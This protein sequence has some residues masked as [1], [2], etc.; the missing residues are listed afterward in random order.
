MSGL[1]SMELHLSYPSQQQLAPVGRSAAGSQQLASTRAPGG[2]PP[3]RAGAP[4]RPTWSKSAKRCT[5][6]RSATSRRLAASV[7]AGSGG[8]RARQGV[9]GSLHKEGGAWAT[10]R[11]LAASAS[12][13]GGAAGRAAAANGCAREQV[14]RHD[15]LRLLST[16]RHWQH[17]A[18]C[19]ATRTRVAAD[20]DHPLKVAQQLDGG[21]VEPRARR[22]HQQR[23][24]VQRVPVQ[25][26]QP[27]I[28]GGSGQ[29]AG[30]WVCGGPA[31]S[32]VESRQA[33]TLCGPQQARGR[34]ASRR[35]RRPASPPRG[36]APARRI[37]SKRTPR[38]QCNRAG[39]HRF[40]ARRSRQAPVNSS[41]DM[42]ATKTLATPFSWKLR[43]AA[44]T[45][46]LETSVATTCGAGAC[47]GGQREARRWQVGSGGEPEDWDT[48]AATARDGWAAADGRR[49]KAGL[50]ARRMCCCPEQPGQLQLPCLPY[51]GLSYHPPPPAAACG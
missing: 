28:D 11:R 36:A 27:A 37:P 4:G 9:V 14:C 18:A 23:G 33:A 13:Q 46:D 34:R 2:A 43:L 29:E 32:G 10:S 8:G 44:A 24:E 42:R 19:R 22:V 45:D 15:Q 31:S 38:T 6:N 25:P 26:L 30:A 7:S 40:M 16:W 35:A 39:A 21:G 48:S 47:H 49:G 12:A 3:H 50:A 51:R 1:R 17:L 41:L 5:S 20:V